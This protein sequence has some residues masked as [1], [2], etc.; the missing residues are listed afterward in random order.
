MMRD[1]RFI[2]V[3]RGGSLKIEQHIQLINW[4]CNCVENVLPLLSEKPDERLKNALSIAKEWATG[5]ASTGNARK[6]SLNAIAVAN[7]SSNSI[8][9][10]VARAA[11]HA[12]ATAHM[13]DHSLSAALYSLKA[14]KNAGKSVDEERE[15]QNKQLPSEIMDLIISTRINKE[16][17]LKL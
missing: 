12:V 17:I 4:A 3:H 5:K 2:A 9:I 7:E 16:K 1:K 14:V 10:A 13:A 8:A 6:A 11:G 15:W